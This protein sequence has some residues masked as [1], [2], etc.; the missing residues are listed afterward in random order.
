MSQPQEHNKTLTSFVKSGKRQ[1]AVRCSCGW[2]T[3]HH[4][5]QSDAL[6]EATG[7][8]PVER[9]RPSGRPGSPRLDRDA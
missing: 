7:H 1:Y 8:P 3:R 6:H 4:D 9:N 2:S 5:Y